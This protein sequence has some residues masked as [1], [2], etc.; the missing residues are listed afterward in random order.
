MILIMEMLT[1]AQQLVLRQLTP[2]TMV[3]TWLDQRHVSAYT[4]GNGV[5]THQ[6]ANVSS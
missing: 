1:S 3:T 5:E 6:S 2:V 4:L